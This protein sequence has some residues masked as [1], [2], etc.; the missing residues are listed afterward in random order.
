MR[1]VLR[2]VL[3]VISALC[4]NAGPVLAQALSGS[5]LTL[6]GVI[7]QNGAG[8]NFFDG[9]NNLFSGRACIGPTCDGTEA[10]E[11]GPLRLKWSEP[12]ILFEDSSSTA[13][14]SSND[15]RLVINDS[16][17]TKFAIQDIDGGTIPF[18]IRGGVPTNSFWLDSTGRLGLG[19]SIP[20]ASVDI[21]TLTPAIR[22]QQTGTA[23]SW[24]MAAGSQFTINDNSAAS[25]PVIF[26]PG[27]PTDSLR[28]EDSGDIGLGTGDPGAQLHLR[29]TDG[30]ARLLVEDASPTQAVREMFAMKNRGGSYFTL[31]NTATNDSWYYVHE[32][33]A[34]NRFLITHSS[35][36]LQMSLNRAGDMTLLGTLYTAG[37]CSSG[38][39]RVFDEDYPL[40]TIAQQAAMMR[41][42]R[43]LPA[44]GPTPEDGPFNIGAMTGGMLNE[45]EKAHLYIV[46][47][48]GR[49][50][51][52]EAEAEA[53]KAVTQSLAA[54][55][56][57]LETHLD[58]GSAP[59]AYR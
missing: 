4:L 49:L 59:A 3:P 50:R 8:T 29:R 58:Q 38:C 42:K 12:D 54:R 39:D 34:P 10:F 45:L 36:G 1:L 46:Q 7:T 21:A 51:A 16:T 13:G 56:K 40:P 57:R 5:N 28:L 23:N 26:E 32:N 41:E 15:W 22:M 14:I 53:Q 48:E 37:F 19:T 17:T 55:L 47:L 27:A 11:Q 6:S 31:T 9:G 35:G 30:T 20:Q 33:N 44:V 2:C 43:H 18:T 24:T 52:Q 25:V